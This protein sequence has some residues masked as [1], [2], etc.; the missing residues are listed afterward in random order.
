MVSDYI[1][2]TRGILGEKIGRARKA[3]GWEK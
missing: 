1:I 2:R 3:I